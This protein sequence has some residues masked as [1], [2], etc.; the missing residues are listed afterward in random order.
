MSRSGFLRLL[1]AAACA[2]CGA[3]DDRPATLEV[4]TLEVLAPSCGLVQCHS[5]TTRTEGLAF[6][7]V[8]ASRASLRDLDVSSGRGGDLLEVIHDKEMPPD[9]PMLDADVALI[10]DWINAGAEGL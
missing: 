6:D 4:V 7:T 3:A 1:V 2:G 9:A 10:E 8:A 5:T